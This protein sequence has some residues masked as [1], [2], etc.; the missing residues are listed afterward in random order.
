MSVLQGKNGSPC[1][2]AH[3]HF[4]LKKERRFVEACVDYY[5]LGVKRLSRT[6]QVLMQTKVH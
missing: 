4:W 1:T 3:C 6:A 5:P 2:A